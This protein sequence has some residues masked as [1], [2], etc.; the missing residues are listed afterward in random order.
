[1]TYLFI[2]QTNHLGGFDVLHELSWVI[3]EDFDNLF[4]YRPFKL[5]ETSAT[6]IAFSLTSVISAKELEF[7]SLDKSI[8]YLENILK[9]ALK[10]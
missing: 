4:K 3:V 2:G 1:M 5:S 7:I 8:Y 9:S 6:D 10:E